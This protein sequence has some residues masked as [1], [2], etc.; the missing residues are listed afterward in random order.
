MA[1]ETIFK[2]TKRG[3]PARRHRKSP[4]VPRFGRGFSFAAGGGDEF[5]GA[6]KELLAPRAAPPP[7][8]GRLVG[9][10]GGPLAAFWK[11][12]PAKHQSALFGGV[13]FPRNSEPYG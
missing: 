10:G 13:R 8:D 7:G 1:S 3:G 2:F 9:A 4:T 5:R 6:G 11:G 12:N